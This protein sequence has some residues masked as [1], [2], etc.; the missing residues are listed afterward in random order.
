MVELYDKG[1]L[2]R[3]ISP[4]LPEIPWAEI[5]GHPSLTHIS[6][7]VRRHFWGPEFDGQLGC[8]EFEA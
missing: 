8:F 5:F 1:V 6:D 2:D 3:M 4:L 7:D